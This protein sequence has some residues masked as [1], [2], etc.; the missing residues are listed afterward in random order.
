[1]Y[2][3]M[4][5]S[6]S[7]MDRIPKFFFCELCK[8]NIQ[9]VFIFRSYFRATLKTKR[10]SSFNGVTVIEFL[11]VVAVV[12]F[13]HIIAAVEFLRCF[14]SVVEVFLPASPVRKQV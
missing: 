11:H 4:S 10:V 9:E 7:I 1:M 12:E 6:P 3:E 14:C 5:K 8:L 2:A 13:L